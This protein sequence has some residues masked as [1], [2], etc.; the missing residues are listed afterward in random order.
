MAWHSFLTRHFKPTT[1]IDGHKYGGWVHWMKPGDRNRFGDLHFERVKTTSKGYKFKL[2]E[3]FT[4]S[5]H[6]TKTHKP[7][8]LEFLHFDPFGLV[9]R[10]TLKAGY[11]WDGP[12]G[13]TIDRMENMGPSAKHD[14]KFQLFR[15]DHLDWET[16]FELSNEA[17]RDDC[18]AAG[19]WGTWAGLYNKG[20]NEF[21]GS[22]AQPRDG[23]GD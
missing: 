15:D 8:F 2:I 5:F 20:L 16:E 23:K 19:M 13:P 11:H 7:V 22:S 9:G 6:M 10:I 21:G 4:F 1:I 14:G 18:K 17:M 12:S 3:D